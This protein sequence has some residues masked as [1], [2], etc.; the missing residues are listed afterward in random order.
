MKKIKANGLILCFYRIFKR[1]EITEPYTSLKFIIFKAK[2]FSLVKSNI[3]KYIVNN[4]NRLWLFN[5][6]NKDFKLYQK[7]FLTDLQK[8]SVIKD[9]ISRLD[10]VPVQYILKQWYFRN[11]IFYIHNNVLIPRIETEKIVDLALEEI[12][13]LINKRIKRNDLEKNKIKT[14]SFFEIGIGSGAIFISLLK[15]FEKLNIDFNKNNLQKQ[16]LTLNCLGID[17][18]ENSC[19]VSNVNAKLL[20]ISDEKFS[21]ENVS[22][23]IFIEKFIDDNKTKKFDFVISNPPYIKE[24][25]KTSMQKDVFSHEDHRAL[26]SG[27][28]GLDLI[29]KIILNSRNLVKKGGF[30]ILEIDEDQTKG[31]VKL[32]IDNKYEKF[33]TEKDI[34]GKERFLI[35]YIN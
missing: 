19:Y 32:M 18:N 14:L 16:K 31:L 28:D 11:N 23:E 20:N 10:H 1:K 30:V 3:M 5:N 17:I 27:E 13:S 29:R 22:F 35:Y 8:R 2:H 26:F 4:K 21:I 33:F 25:S 7:L 9:C 6:F 12:K 34:F 24:N 15:E